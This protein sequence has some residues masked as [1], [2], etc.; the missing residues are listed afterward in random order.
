VPQLERNPLANRPPPRAIAA[1]R[2]LAGLSQSEVASKAG[3]GA[4]SFGRYEKG[5]SKLIDRNFSRLAS[6]LQRHGIGFIQQDEDLALGVCLLHGAP[7]L[8]KDP[9]LRKPDA[10]VQVEEVVAWDWLVDRPP[11]RLVVAARYLLG[12]SQAA[13]ASEAGIADSTLLRYEKGLIRLRDKNFT[14]VL[15]TFKKHRV[16]FI[17]PDAEIAIGVSLLNGAPLPETDPFFKGP[18]DRRTVD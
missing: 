8:R 16:R 9:L 6:L 17:G 10:P 18:S 14:A 3:I 4:R 11:P 7:S 1:A 12:F 2:A 15:R 5:L 13:F